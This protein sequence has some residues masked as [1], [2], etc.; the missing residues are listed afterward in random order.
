MVWDVYAHVAEGYAILGLGDKAQEALDAIG[1]AGEIASRLDKVVRAK[2]DVFDRE[3]LRKSI[4]NSANAAFPFNKAGSYLDD[5]T[6]QELLDLAVELGLPEVVLEQ[7]RR[8]DDYAA[9]KDF[10]ALEPSRQDE[11]HTS[12]LHATLLRNDFAGAE[13]RIAEIADPNR[14]EYG[15]ML[16]AEALARSGDTQKAL[17]LSRDMAPVRRNGVEVAAA[18]NT[19]LNGDPEVARRL[20]QGLGAQDQQLLALDIG[21]SGNLKAMALMRSL[22]GLYERAWLGKEIMQLQIEAGDLDLA[23]R[24]AFGIDEVGIRADAN[25]ILA[26]AAAKKGRSDLVTKAGDE[27]AAMRR[28]NVDAVE[29]TNSEIMLLFAYAILLRIDDATSQSSAIR[30]H[31]DEIVPSAFPDDPF[32]AMG[33]NENRALLLIHLAGA[34]LALGLPDEAAKTFDEMGDGGA[35]DS[36]FI[37]AEA[38]GLAYSV[39]GPDLASDAL[40]RSLSTTALLKRP[41]D[42]AM[43]L[44]RLAE[45][46]L[47]KR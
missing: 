12:V 45:V 25:A 7:E 28:Q 33:A 9:S 24:T 2:P 22:S 15:N 6:W 37:L 44:S 42:R 27:I 4:S 20:V 11:A 26:I 10:A 5:Y 17:A 46:M 29:V 32:G 39:G 23:E 35:E 30:K 34:Q 3:W 1:N 41:M 13:R 38:A 36:A 19:V 31:I 47:I 8:F 16:L 40:R 21:K 14:K 43:M 18:K